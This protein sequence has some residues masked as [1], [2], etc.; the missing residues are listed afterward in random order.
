MENKEKTISNLSGV[1]WKIY[2]YLKERTMQ[3]KWSS[4]Q[5]LID[6]LE[7]QNIKI[8]K[9]NLRLHIQNIRKCEIIQKVI[10]T[11]YSKG[12]RIM[13]DEE[14]YE[15]LLK[16]K[17]SILKSLKQFHKDVKRLELN[18][19]MKLVFDTKERKIIE[20]LLK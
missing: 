3:D 11:S 13:S 5:D 6:Y 7:T 18:N 16:R 9:R 1:E 17:I 15:I 14:Q 8:S 20:S 19:Q 12:Y 2:N 4:Q 10:L